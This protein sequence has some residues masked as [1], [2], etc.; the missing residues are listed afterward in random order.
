M[1]TTESGGESDPFRNKVIII[2]TTTTNARELNPTLVAF[3]LIAPT[4]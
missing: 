4:T 2:Y 1:Y 3:S